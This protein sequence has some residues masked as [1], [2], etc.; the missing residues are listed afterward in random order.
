MGRAPPLRMARARAKSFLPAR[1][2]L[3]QKRAYMSVACACQLDIGY[4]RTR[5]EFVASALLRRTPSRASTRGI[6]IGCVRNREARGNANPWYASAHGLSAAPEAASAPTWYCWLARSRWMRCSL[7]IAD[8]GSLDASLRGPSRG[9][10]ST[11]RACAAARLRFSSA[12]WI[13]RGPASNATRN[14]R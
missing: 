4:P 12:R 7:R 8:G 2:R 9:R 14:G 11:P 3:S 1:R 13:C 5:Q 10:V 6:A